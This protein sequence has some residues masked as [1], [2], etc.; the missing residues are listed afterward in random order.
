MKLVNINT[1]IAELMF[2]IGYKDA[3]KLFFVRLQKG[4][5]R[6][7]KAENISKTFSAQAYIN[8]PDKTIK[9]N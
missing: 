3:L 9:I 6:K 7:R 4:S 5:T 2:F 8:L 1:K